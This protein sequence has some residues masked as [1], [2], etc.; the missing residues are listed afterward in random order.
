MLDSFVP[1][2]GLQFN[3]SGLILDEREIANALTDTGL[4]PV[5]RLVG[6]NYV[7]QILV[8]RN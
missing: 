2:N 1:A 3:D 5:I 7:Y 6:S 8:G 4:V